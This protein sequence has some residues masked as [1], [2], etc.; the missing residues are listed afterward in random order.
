MRQERR[1]A[2]SWC[3][4]RR[5]H[6]MIGY[7]LSLSLLLLLVKLPASISFIVASGMD[8]LMAPRPY[9]NEYLP[10]ITAH[11]LQPDAAPSR[12]SLPAETVEDAR[13]DGDA[14][15]EPAAAETPQLVSVDSPV[16][17]RR[18]EAIATSVSLVSLAA[19]TRYMHT[20]I[21]TPTVDDAPR[22]RI[23]TMLIEYP[24]AALKKAIQGLVIVRFTVETDGRA[25]GINVVSGL[26]PECDDAVVSALKDARFIPGSYDGRRV[27]ALSQIAVHFKIVDD[28]PW[29]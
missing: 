21:S 5:V 12:P 4:E 9:E 27:P 23:G 10:T 7:V 13:D 26:G 17:T 29:P 20:A 16:S 19:T 11:E 6:L 1:P 18:P 15:E 8:D 24:L 25:Y 22:L 3:R 2:G 14:N 28:R